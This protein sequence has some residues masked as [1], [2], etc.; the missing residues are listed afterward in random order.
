MES[1][2]AGKIRCGRGEGTKK[3]PFGSSSRIT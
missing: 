1:C 2:A 3:D